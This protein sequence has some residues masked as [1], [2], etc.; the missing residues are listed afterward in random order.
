MEEEEERERGK[1]GGGYQVERGHTLKQNVGKRSVPQCQK[2][3][4][5]RQF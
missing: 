3:K 1:K 5:V 2:E 4:E